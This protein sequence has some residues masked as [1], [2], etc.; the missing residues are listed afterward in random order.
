MV[1]TLSS[2]SAVNEVHSQ[3]A[4]SSIRVTCE[5]FTVVSAAQ[6]IKA[7]SPITCTPSGN[8][9]SC[10]AVQ[11][12]KA[13]SG[14]VGVAL[15]PVTS[16]RSH[17]VICVLSANTPHC[18]PIPILESSPFSSISVWPASRAAQMVARATTSVMPVTSIVPEVG[19]VKFFRRSLI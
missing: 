8:V 6:R 15:Q 12:L 1:V 9:T 18:P 4:Y 2:V 14:R 13:S 19:G 11:S 17:F 5:R 3:N 10:K 7:Y 16:V